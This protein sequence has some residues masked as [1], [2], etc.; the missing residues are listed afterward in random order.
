MRVGLGWY[1]CLDGLCQ[2]A[3]RGYIYDWELVAARDRADGL[4]ADEV[5]DR[6]LRSEVLWANNM[7]VLH[8]QPCVGSRYEPTGMTRVVP[9]M[10]TKRACVHLP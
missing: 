2:R 3:R 10:A 6:F 5:P 4:T 7:V 9:P 8:L 1:G